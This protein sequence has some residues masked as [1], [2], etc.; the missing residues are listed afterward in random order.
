MRRDG[1]TNSE[2]PFQVRTVKQIKAAAAVASVAIGPVV[3]HS[4]WI[5]DAMTAPAGGWPLVSVDDDLR[6]E[7]EA[8]ILGIVAGWKNA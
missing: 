2:A 7:I 5:N 6:V 4:I 3:I 8:A 1:A